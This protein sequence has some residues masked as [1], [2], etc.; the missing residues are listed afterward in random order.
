MTRLFS[1]IVFKRRHV[2]GVTAVI[3]VLLASERPAAAQTFQGAYGGIDASRQHL[4]GG[5]LVDGIDTLQEDSRLVV[6]AFGGLRVQARGFV[7]GG[8]LGRGWTDGDLEL[9][10][11]PLRVDF[12]NGSQWHWALQAGHT[13]G[14]RTLLFGYLS[15]VT[16]QFDVSIARS[17]QTTSQQDEQ[18]LLRFGAGIEQQLIGRLHLRLAAGTSRADF[19]NRPTNIE[20][21]H[22]FEL[23]GG[24]VLQF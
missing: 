12:T 20:I 11:P 18:G 3:G 10:A 14:D 6:S 1:S 7:I 2:V 5:S 9:E 16:R 19:G 15:E 21:G 22:R 23:G 17:G 8:E 13:I 24:L 4:I